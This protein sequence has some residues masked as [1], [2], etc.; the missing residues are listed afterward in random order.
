[1]RLVIDDLVTDDI[2][3]ATLTGLRLTLIFGILTFFITLR[4]PDRADGR[5]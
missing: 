3:L 4:L 5:A 2:D 1:V